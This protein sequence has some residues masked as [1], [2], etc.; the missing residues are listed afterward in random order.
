MLTLI[1]SYISLTILLVLL[2]KSLQRVVERGSKSKKLSNKAKRKREKEHQY[3]EN[4]LETLSKDLNDKIVKSITNLNGPQL[5]ESGRLHKTNPS[6]VTKT[7]LFKALKITKKLNCITEVVKDCLTTAE[8]LDSKNAFDLPLYNVPVTLKECF[9]TKGSASTVG[10]SKFL[11]NIATEDCVLVKVLKHCGAVPFAKTNLPQMMLS[12][13]ASNPIYGETSHPLNPKFGPGGSSS[14]EGCII[15]AGGSVLGFGTDTGGSIRIP[16]HICGICSFKPTMNRLS[17]SGIIGPNAM[18]A[19]ATSAGPMARDID[20]IVMAMRALCCEKM[21]ELDPHVVPIKFRDQMYTNKKPLRI[22]YFDDDGYMKPIPACQRA[23]KITKESLEEAGHTLVPYKPYEKLIMEDLN[24]AGFA[25]GGESFMELLENDAVDVSIKLYH[26]IWTTPWIFRKIYAY[27]LSFKYPRIAKNY[28]AYYGKGD[29]TVNKLWKMRG[30]IEQY[31]S[32]FWKEWREKYKIDA[33]ICPV[34]PIVASPKG[35]LSNLTAMGSYTAVFNLVNGPAGTVPVTRVTQ[36]DVDDLQT[37]KDHYE[38]S[39]SELVK[40]ACS[41][42]INMPV[43]VQCASYPFR[44]EVCLRLMK[45]V[46]SLLPMKN[47]S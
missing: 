26:S 13:E 4:Q 27:F 18:A 11:D 47:D 24:C 20:T 34:S 35:N 33:L 19:L 42:S 21:F 25:D 41:G 43:S 45:E 23:I 7:F 1:L 9:Q 3:N 30:K 37:Y 46:E 38:D 16:G 40:N 39:L 17:Q 5:I 36:E 22:G 32:E 29:T 6:L 28:E 31:K 2:V 15:A 12:F 44:E 14:G 8:N 10:I